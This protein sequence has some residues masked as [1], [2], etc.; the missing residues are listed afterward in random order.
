MRKGVAEMIWGCLL[1]TV[2]GFLSGAVMYSYLIPKH[3]FHVDVCAMSKD[4]NPGSS[5]V[6][7]LAGVRA[8]AACMALD[9]AKAFF[10]VFAAVSVVGLRGMYLVPV[11][12]APVAGHAFS[13]MLG[14][15]GGKA[16][17]TA[18]GSLLGL[19]TLSRFVL[20]LALTLAFFRFV[21]SVRPDS[22]GVVTGMTAAGVAAIF[23]L[24]ALWLKSA[25]LLI[26]VIVVYRHL[27]RP[28]EGPCYIKIGRRKFALK[29]RRPA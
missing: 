16:V 5:N 6:I 17:S 20:I 21:I 10:P 26:I 22:A 8:G 14:F 23:F 2:L 3:F 27:R 24:Q 25:V 15:H 29:S 1:M 28:D 13:P 4:G 12:V 11:A 19:L 9:V 7:R 18:F